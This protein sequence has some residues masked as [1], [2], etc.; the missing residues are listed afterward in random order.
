MVGVLTRGEDTE[1][2]VCQDGREIGV[3]MPQAKEHLGPSEAERGKEG[4]LKMLVTIKG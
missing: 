2:S 1:E 3:M 4:S